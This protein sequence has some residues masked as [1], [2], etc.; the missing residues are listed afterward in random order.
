MSFKNQVLRKTRPRKKDLS[1]PELLVE[2][3]FLYVCLEGGLKGR[4]RASWSPSVMAE[5]LGAFG[6][7]LWETHDIEHV[8][9]I[10]NHCHI[11]VREGL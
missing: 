7:I 1:R 8:V 5:Q 9:S 10:K 3:T 11:G 4:H 2:I 6:Q